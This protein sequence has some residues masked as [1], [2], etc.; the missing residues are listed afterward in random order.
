MVTGKKFLGDLE[1]LLGKEDHLGNEENLL[2]RS[3]LSD[4]NESVLIATFRGLRNGDT[5]EG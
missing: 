5:S 3:A 2:V 4:G 1:V